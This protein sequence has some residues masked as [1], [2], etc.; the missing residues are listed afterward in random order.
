MNTPEQ[1]LIETITNQL[2]R[3]NKPRLKA[4]LRTLMCEIAFHEADQMEAAAE[5]HDNDPEAG[6]TTNDWQGR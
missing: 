5:A 2:E 3:L 1:K 6:P 4:V